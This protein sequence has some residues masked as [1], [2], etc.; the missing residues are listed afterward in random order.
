[1][2]KLLK[3]FFGLMSFIS[4]FVLMAS[5]I[6]F[7]PGILSFF[8]YVLLSEPKTCLGTIKEL[9][10]KVLGAFFKK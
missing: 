8:I 5:V 1:M 6:L 2:K 4:Y 9:S 7:V 3:I 10:T